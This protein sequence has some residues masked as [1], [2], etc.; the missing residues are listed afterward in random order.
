MRAESFGEVRA[1]SPKGAMGLMQIIPETWAHLRVRYDLG[2]DPMI[3]TTTSWPV[4]RICASCTTAMAHP[5]FWLPTMPV[6]RAM[7][8]I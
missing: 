5:D 6:P 4:L 2:A 3:R 8:I 7:R 1:I